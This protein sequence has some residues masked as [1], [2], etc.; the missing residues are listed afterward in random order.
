MTRKAT[1]KIYQ[2]GTEPP[3]S[4][5]WRDRTPEER[6]MEVFRLRAMWGADREPMQRVVAIRPL[7]K[8][9]G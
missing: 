7:K 2:K 3:A 8:L 5:E 6:I 4:A 9:G 1:V